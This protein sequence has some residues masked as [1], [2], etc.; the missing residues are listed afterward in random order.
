VPNLEVHIITIIFWRDR[1]LTLRLTSC[2]Q[3]QC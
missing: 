1:V 3:K 2:I